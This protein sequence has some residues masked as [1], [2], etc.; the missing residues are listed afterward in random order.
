MKITD[1]HVGQIVVKWNDD[2]KHEV[3]HIIGLSES[4]FG[5]IILDVKWVGRN[6][7][8]IHPGNVQ[9]MSDFAV[10]PPEQ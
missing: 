9:P 1:C 7:I 10:W 2:G 6:E 5:E 4:L 8:E 3:G